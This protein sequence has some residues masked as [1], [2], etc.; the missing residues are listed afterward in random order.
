MLQ[1]TLEHIKTSIF[2]RFGRLP[3][4][5]VALFGSLVA[6]WH[7]PYRVRRLPLV[8][9]VLF[10]GVVALWPRPIVININ[11]VIGRFSDPIRR[12]VV[13][14]ESVGARSEQRQCSV[15]RERSI[16]C[17][18]RTI[19]V[20]HYSGTVYVLTCKHAF[21]MSIYCASLKIDFVVRWKSDENQLYVASRL[22]KCHLEVIVASK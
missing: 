22:F 16:P 20:K 4:V 10:D 12:L 18:V 1:N 9:L 21:R 6:L 7:H 19:V 2:I 8:N 3:L 17:R 15:K 13:V 11:R 5:N 14:I